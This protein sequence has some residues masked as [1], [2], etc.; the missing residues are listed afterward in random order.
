MIYFDI[1]VFC[2]LGFSLLIGF[3]RGVIREIFGL[4]S[5]G[6]ALAASYFSFPF[7]NKIVLQYI[8]NPQIAQYVTYFAVFIAFLILFSIVSSLLSSFIRQTV[9]SGIDRTLG[10]GFGILRAFFILGVVDLGL[11]VFYPRE[12]IPPFLQNSVTIKHMHLL[13]DELFSLFPFSL[14][15][16]VKEKL[17]SPNDVKAP[18]S[19]AKTAQDL[20]KEQQQ[21]LEDLAHLKPQ[22]TEPAVEVDTKAVKSTV[23]SIGKI[24]ENAV[25]EAVQST[26]QNTNQQ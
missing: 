24:V 14:Q 19:I 1:G 12:Q 15:Q 23:D 21:N 4:I 9:L 22:A 6:A 2:I 7:A 10:F 25:S 13:G 17:K 16:I 8:Q 11:S 20:I 26:I 5:W 3:V 18:T